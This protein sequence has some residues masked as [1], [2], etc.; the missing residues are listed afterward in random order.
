MGKLTVPVWLNNVFENILWKIEDKRKEKVFTKDTMVIGCARIGGDY[1]I[2]YEKASSI[3]KED[4]GKP[5]HCLIVP[6]KL[7]FIEEEALEM[8]R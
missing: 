2:K 7:H 1:K 5:L 6:G 3:E 8:W 4:F